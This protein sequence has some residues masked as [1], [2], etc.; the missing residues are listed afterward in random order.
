MQIFL[1]G[2][3]T[4]SRMDH[5]L[6]EPNALSIVP[7]PSAVCSLFY[8]S[9]HLTWNLPISIVLPRIF[10]HITPLILY[11]SFSPTY[12]IVLRRVIMHGIIGG[13]ISIHAFYCS[14]SCDYAWN[15][16]HGYFLE[17]SIVTS[18]LLTR[19]FFL[20]LVLYF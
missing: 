18:H 19:S 1:N 13:A 5:R 12:P 14:S 20:S 6:I 7:P 4:G 3:L 11:S 16:L 15:F 9:S 2:F 17:H 10:Q 8:T